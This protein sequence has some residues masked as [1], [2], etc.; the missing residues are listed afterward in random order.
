MRRIAAAPRVKRHI[1]HLP[2]SYVCLFTAT[3][4]DA[5]QTPL[6][7]SRIAKSCLIKGWDI[8]S[9]SQAGTVEDG[10]ARHCLYWRTDL[11]RL[12]KERAFLPFVYIPTAAATASRMRAACPPERRRQH[13]RDKEA[14]ERLS[15]SLIS[16]DPR[17]MNQTTPPSGPGNPATWE[18]DTSWGTTAARGRPAMLPWDKRLENSLCPLFSDK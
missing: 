12:V 17:H 9:S 1:A 5:R 2:K 4:P 10:Q 15:V 13:R 16:D 3:A 14:K 8:R 18:C 11:R 6:V 7:W